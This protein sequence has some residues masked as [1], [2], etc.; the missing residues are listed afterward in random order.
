MNIYSVPPKCPTCNGY[1]VISEGEFTDLT[2]PDCLGEGDNRNDY[3]RDR[4]SL[5][6]MIENLARNE[7]E[8]DVRVFIEKRRAA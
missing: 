7:A 5:H 6:T 1:G 4:D 8:W 3:E 2:C